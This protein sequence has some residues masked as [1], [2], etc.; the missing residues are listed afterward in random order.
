M[1][2]S[3]IQYKLSLWHETLK[4]HLLE[5]TVFILNYKLALFLQIKLVSLDPY[6]AI[7]YTILLYIYKIFR[8]LGNGSVTIKCL[9]CMYEDLGLDP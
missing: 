4:S 9:L 8:T 3:K 2:K 1:F 7:K 6:A 5:I